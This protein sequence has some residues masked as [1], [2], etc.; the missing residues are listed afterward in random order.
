M[1][2]LNQAEIKDKTVL[3][4][5]DY[6]ITLDLNGKIID[7]IK[8]ISTLPTIKYLKDQGAKKIIIISHFGRPIIR[9]KEKIENIIKGNK[10]LVMVPIVEK[11]AQALKINL[12]K[13]KLAYENNFSLP[14]YKLN[15]YLLVC[16]NIRFDAREEQNDKT[17]SYEM[18]KLADIYVDDAFGNVHREH[19][20]MVGITNFL[21]SYAGLLM[22]KE[23]KNLTALLKKPPK[24][25]VLILGGAKTSEKIMILKNLVKKAD[26]ILLGGV[27]ANTFL[28]G[29]N[30]NMKNSLYDR[31]SVA[32]ANDLYSSAAGKFFLPTDL[33]WRGSS[34]V[35]ISKN[36]IREFANVIAEAK[37]IFWNG[38]MGLTS[39][40]NFKYSNGTWAIVKAIAD[41]S[42]EIKIICGGD[43]IAEVNKM[44]M[45]R[46]MT[47][48]STGGGAALAFLAGRDLPAVDALN[49]NYI[50]KKNKS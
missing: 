20:S 10:N 34:A 45:I 33:V 4:R 8:I 32:F 41:S 46:R 13:I 9:P 28:V 2:T 15:D 19:A 16:E 6:N 7:D 48:V 1:K 50:I 18:S 26:K 5:A 30:I 17:F 36:T 44:K 3:L 24:P 21:P 49:S 22:E 25:F 23:I 14:F 35:D 27:M 37:T 43:T 47:H 29:R 40:G 31:E 38:T 42:A 11:L 12:K 39:M